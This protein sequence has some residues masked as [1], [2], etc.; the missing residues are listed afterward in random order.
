MT[1]L[2]IAGVGLLGAVGI[3]AFGYWLGTRAEEREASRY[4][5]DVTS[6]MALSCANEHLV[7]LTDFR[8]GRTEEGVR[9]LEL[10]VAAKLGNLDSKGIA[11]TTIAKR[12]FSNLQVPLAAYQA[13]FKSPL[14]DPKTNPE[15]VNLLGKGQ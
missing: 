2:A 6:H 13:K 11:D 7:A 3:F 1:R 15:L 12:S 9:G 14:L 5:Y 10:L 4:L 8:E